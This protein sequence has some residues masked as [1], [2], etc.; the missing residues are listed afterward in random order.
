MADGD[1]T[2]AM[3]LFMLQ[4]G[5]MPSEVAG[6]IPSY[7]APETL[8]A[9]PPFVVIGNDDIQTINQRQKIYKGLTGARSA[10]CKK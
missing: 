2:A 9:E 7:I 5:Q 3:I 1:E 6:W 8:A 4:G 10:S